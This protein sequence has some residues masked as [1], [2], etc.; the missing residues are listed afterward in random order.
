MLVALS[1]LQVLAVMG[2]VACEIITYPSQSARH[3]HIKST[4]SPLYHYIHFPPI[5][6]PPPPFLREM[7]KQQQHL[8]NQHHEA[9]AEA[10]QPISIELDAKQLTALEIIADLIE[11]D[12]DL[13]CLAPVLESVGM[14]GKDQGVK[15]RKGREG[16][17]VAVLPPRGGRK[18]IPVSG[19]L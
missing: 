7:S 14:G 1:T 17:R 5:H 10:A 12:L 11:F 13:K 19:I 15:D 4:S 8:D 3:S 2:G 18:S 6:S 16:Q 9:E